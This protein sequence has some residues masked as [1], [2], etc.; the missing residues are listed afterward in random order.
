MKAARAT[1]LAAG[2]QTVTEVL[3]RHGFSEFGRFS[4]DYRAL[5]GERPIDTLNRAKGARHDP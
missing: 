3:G 2:T 5:F 4:R 1:L